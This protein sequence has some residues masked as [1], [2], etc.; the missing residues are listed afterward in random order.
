MK[1]V[2][3]SRMPRRLPSMS[4]STRA[5]LMITRCGNSSGMMEVMAATPA[6]TDTA[7]VTT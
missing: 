2:P 3:D 4:S 1:I 7:T 5:T 6:E